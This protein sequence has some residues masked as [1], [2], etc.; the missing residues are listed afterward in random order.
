MKWSGFFG[1]L[2]GA[3]LFR[4][5]GKPAVK[6]ASFGGALLGWIVA[7]LLPK[8]L[9]NCPR[10]GHGKALPPGRSVVY[11]RWAAGWCPACKYS[12]GEPEK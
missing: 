8:P 1:A 9:T 3:A 4:K 7:A 5:L 2:L 10:C 11:R 6:L 12:W